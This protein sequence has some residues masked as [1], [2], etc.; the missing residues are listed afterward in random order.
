MLADYINEVTAELKSLGRKS[1]IWGDMLL[2]GE[3][4]SPSKYYANHHSKLNSKK[5]L[6]LLT[7]DTVIADWQYNIE[8][9]D[10]NSAA[11]FSSE[12]FELMMCPWYNPE[13]IAANIDIAKR[14]NAGILITTWNETNRFITQLLNA[15]E[16]AAS[17][18]ATGIIPYRTLTVAFLRKL[19]PTSDRKKAGFK[20]INLNIN[21]IME[22]DI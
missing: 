18:S 3:D 10:D 12:G 19:L 15:A 1:I 20:G 2:N 6:K 14:Y 7:R 21:E 8:K 17:G 5:T 9:A 22:M 4:F 16:L 11:F 13:N